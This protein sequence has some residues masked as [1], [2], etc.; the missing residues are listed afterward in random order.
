MMNLKDQTNAKQTQSPTIMPPAHVYPQSHPTL[1]KAL[2][3]SPSGSPIHGIMSELVQKLEYCSINK[4]D[5]NIPLFFLTLVIADSIPISALGLVHI[6]CF[7]NKKLL[8]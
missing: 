5:L 7:L 2:D 1:C 8:G 6:S 4:N 3:C